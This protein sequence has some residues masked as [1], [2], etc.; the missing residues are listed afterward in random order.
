MRAGAPHGICAY[1]VEAMSVLRIEKGHV[2][3]NEINGTVTA[4]DLG[5]AK[6]VSKSKT[7]FIGRAMLNREGLTDAG[8]WRLVGLLPLDSGTTLRAGAHVLNAADAASLDNDQ[9]YV[10][11]SCYSPHMRSYIALAL[12]RRG[13]ERHGETVQVWNALGSEYARARITGPVFV[14]SENRRLHG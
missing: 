11:S 1:G 13:G 8:R 12:V 6:L 14:D 10:T 5:M 7:D 4:A 9:G 2:T 3:H